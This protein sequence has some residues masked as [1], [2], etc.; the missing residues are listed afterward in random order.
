MLN[1]L[2]P[3]VYPGSFG[4]QTLPESFQELRAFLCSAPIDISLQQRNQDLVGFSLAYPLNRS[5]SLSTTWL[6]STLPSR[7]LICQR[8]HSLYSWQQQSPSFECFKGNL[9]DARP[10]LESF[11][12]KICVNSVSCLFTHLYSLTCRKFS[13]SR[14]DQPLAI[15]FFLPS[16][17]SL[18]PTWSTS[19]IKNTKI[20][21]RSMQMNYTLSDMLTTDLYSVVSI[22]QTNGS[23]K[24]FLQ[25]LLLWRVS[26]HRF[27]CQFKNTLISTA[28]C[29]FSVSSFQNCRH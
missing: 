9:K 7:L 17:T 1:I 22:W 27:R 15:R 6:H 21:W 25:F 23:C 4:L 10:E 14:E 2:L 28:S 11:G 13:N 29:L 3:A 20:L 19:G 16:P 24:S 12:S 8:L 5:W 18:S 26:W